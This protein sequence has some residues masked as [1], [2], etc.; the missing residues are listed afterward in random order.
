M[1][2]GSFNTGVVKRGGLKGISVVNSL[3]AP[4]R[5]RAG[6]RLARLPLGSWPT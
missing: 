3:N 4:T 5:L 2:S 6:A 1:V